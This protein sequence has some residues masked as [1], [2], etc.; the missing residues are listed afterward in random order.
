[1][2]GVLRYVNKR[3]SNLEEELVSYTKDPEVE[4]LHSIRVEI[5][6]IKTLLLLIK[7]CS[8][9][10]KAHKTFIPLRTI[11]RRAGEIRQPD[12]F[13]RLLLLYQ[14]QGVQD[15]AIPKSKS[16]V[17]LNDSFIRQIPAHLK[18]VK[19]LR[20][21]V[22]QQAG[23]INRRC[24]RK[25]IEKRKRALRSEL[26]PRLHL[27][28]LHKSRKA[29]KEIIYLSGVENG[30]R[31]L[32]KFYRRIESLVGKWH[33]RQMLTYELIRNKT[34]AEVKRLTTENEADIRKIKKMVKKYYQ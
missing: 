21:I 16:A 30:G 28:Q 33:D 27:D 26:H 10:F 32:D 2:K 17:R 12:V 15:E 22:S 29:M 4:I 34:T 11:F 14:I 9:K 31:K 3:F 19:R 8:K 23:K 5:K 24:I 25:Y 18:T 7:Y 20:Q 1:M 13:Y 6:K